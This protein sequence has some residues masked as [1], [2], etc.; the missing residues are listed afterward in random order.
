M[1]LRLRVKLKRDSETKILFSKKQGKLGLHGE[2]V[3]QTCPQYIIIYI[4]YL[5][6]MLYPSNT[7]FS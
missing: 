2:H 1:E 7:V 6:D 4:L 3:I 5:L